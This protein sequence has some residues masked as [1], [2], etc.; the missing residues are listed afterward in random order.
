MVEGNPY[1][2]KDSWLNGGVVTALAAR[3]GLRPDDPIFQAAYRNLL[4]DVVDSRFTDHF[5]NLFDRELA[6]LRIP[7]HQP[8]SG[9]GDLPKDPEQ[10]KAISFLQSIAPAFLSRFFKLH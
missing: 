7:A 6:L 2:N 4:A 8:P 10:P 9:N 3:S 5:L 1:T